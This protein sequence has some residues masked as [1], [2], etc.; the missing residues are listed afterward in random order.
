[1]SNNKTITDLPTMTEIIAGRFSTSSSA[2]CTPVVFLYKEE[3]PTLDI[4]STH[5][6]Q[7]KLSFKI[8]EL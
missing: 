1:M 4:T 8:P 6:E 5:T 7:Y 2:N 3:M